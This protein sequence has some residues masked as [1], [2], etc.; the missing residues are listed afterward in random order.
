MF[1]G[2]YVPTQL[3][4]LLKPKA[5]AYQATCLSLTIKL[6]KWHFYLEKDQ[7]TLFPLSWGGGSNYIEM[8]LSI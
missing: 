1:C 2:G 4:Y 7:F 6:K 8:L 5:I 3:S